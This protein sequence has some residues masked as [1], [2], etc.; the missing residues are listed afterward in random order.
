M[1]Q[2]YLIL[3]SYSSNYHLYS[4][5]LFRWWKS[6]LT[7]NIPLLLQCSAWKPLLIF[8]EEDINNL[9]SRMTCLESWLTAICCDVDYHIWKNKILLFCIPIIQFHEKIFF[10]SWNSIFTCTSHELWGIIHNHRISRC[11]HSIFFKC[12]NFSMIFCSKMDYYCMYI[13]FRKCT[14]LLMFCKNKIFLVFQWIMLKIH[15]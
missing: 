4:L 8:V 10:L 5:F 15:E 12:D 2:N 3:I 13:F 6:A 11:P 1:L 9:V 7:Y 14:F